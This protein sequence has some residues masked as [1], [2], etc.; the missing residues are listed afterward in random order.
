MSE[1]GGPGEATLSLSK[2]DESIVINPD[3]TDQVRT[4]KSDTSSSSTGHS[5]ATTTVTVVT[6]KTPTRTE[7]VKTIVSVCKDS[8]ADENRDASSTLALPTITRTTTKEMTITTGTAIVRNLEEHSTT[9]TAPS[10]ELSI[11]SFDV[12]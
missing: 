8:A 1:P 7:V 11:T 2:A 12:L 9:T 3:V 6:T 5:R 10:T 4:E